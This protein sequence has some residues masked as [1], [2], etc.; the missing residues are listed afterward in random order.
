[1]FWIFKETRHLE[2]KQFSAEKGFGLPWCK[3]YLRFLETKA[4]T[5]PPSEKSIPGNNRFKLMLD[6]DHKLSVKHDQAPVKVMYEARTNEQ[7]LS[8]PDSERI[9]DK[10]P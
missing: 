2:D 5:E 10:S 8:K 1:M 9:N 7:K 6:M 3:T 4:L